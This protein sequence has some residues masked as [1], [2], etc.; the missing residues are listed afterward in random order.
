MSLQSRLEA[1][2]T[3]VANYLRDS[4]LPRLVPSGGA[5][6]ALLAKT[7]GTNYALG[8]VTPQKQAIAVAC[9]D[10][11]TA[12]TAG[13][14]KITFVMPFAFALSSVLGSLTTAQP[15]GSILTVNVKAAG[16]SIFTT[17]LTIDN[18]E[19]DSSTAAA[20]A[21]LT[22]TPLTIPA[23]TKITVDIDQ[24]GASGAAGL[25]LYFVGTPA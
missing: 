25:K 14:A 3:G 2:A 18:T 5:T 16:T 1:L 23:Y 21:V 12:L 15:S 17:K 10:E 20:A 19:T 22:A 24:V 8:W 13:A 4:I 6:G 11:S 9:S 7:S